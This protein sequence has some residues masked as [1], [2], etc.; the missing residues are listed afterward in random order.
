[1]FCLLVPR[2]IHQ[3]KAEVNGMIRRRSGFEMEK[4]GQLAHAEEGSSDVPTSATDCG[5][6]SLSRLRTLMLWNWP[7]QAGAIRDLRG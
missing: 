5:L 7:C 1:M 3:V 2:R 6:N 4:P